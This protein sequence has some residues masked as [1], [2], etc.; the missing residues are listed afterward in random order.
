[1]T[2][3]TEITPQSM[4]ERYGAR[5]PRRRILVLAPAV[6]VVGALLVWGVWAAWLSSDKAIDAHLSAY[7]VVSTHEVRVKVTARF[8]DADV[9][10]S[11]LLR[12]TARDHTIVGELNLTA[13]DLRA[14]RGTWIPIRTERRATTATLVRC[15]E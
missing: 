3:R 2:D 10:G 7:E 1:M 5:R 6:L 9:G 4:E 15:S 8:R 14:G 13:D 11:C 12:A